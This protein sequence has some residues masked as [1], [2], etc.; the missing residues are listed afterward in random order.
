MHALL[1][2]SIP[3]SVPFS[4]I[5]TLPRDEWSDVS[6]F[7]A[8]NPRAILPLNR[9]LAIA[10]S[11]QGCQ[12]AFKI[13]RAKSERLNR[14]DGSV[15]D[16]DRDAESCRILDRLM[17]SGYVWLPA[18]AILLEELPVDR[19]MAV[20]V[21]VLGGFFSHTTVSTPASEKY[22]VVELGI[23]RENII[24]KV[25]KLDTMLAAIIDHESKP[26]SEYDLEAERKAIESLVVELSVHSL[27]PFPEP[28]TCL[29]T[30][31]VLRQGF[32]AH[33]ISCG[34]SANSEHIKEMQT[35]LRT[36]LLPTS[37]GWLRCFIK[38]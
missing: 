33:L 30:D 23:V 6:W 35:I 29:D 25:S 38:S 21:R 4:T 20:C 14:M 31:R 8:M 24:R 13:F 19:L 26:A 7:D 2:E 18:L 1:T 5:K 3:I 9:A 22:K 37:P 34:W 16:D 10:A 12:N 36:R 11:F 15:S 27:Q 32:L 17:H 28:T